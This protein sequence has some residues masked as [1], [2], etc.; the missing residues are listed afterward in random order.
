[1]Q[2]EDV[3]FSEPSQVYDSK[4]NL[5]TNYRLDGK[6]RT[7]PAQMAELMGEM[8]RSPEAK[9]FDTLLLNRDATGMRFGDLLQALKDDSGS[10]FPKEIICHFCRPK[11][12]SAMV[13]H[14]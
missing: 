3:D 12:D 1:M 5:M 2:G 6:I 9:S 14:L 13:V 11:D 10:I 8:R 4:K 7:L